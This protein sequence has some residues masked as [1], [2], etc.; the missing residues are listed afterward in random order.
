MVQLLLDK[1]ADIAVPTKDGWTP[2][3]SAANKGHSGVVQL[4]LDNVGDIAGL[5]NNEW[6][7][8]NSAAAKR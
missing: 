6:T 7:L 2:L 4:L 8:L 1:G 3:H 5:D